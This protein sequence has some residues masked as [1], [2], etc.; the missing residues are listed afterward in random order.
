MTW[1]F[2]Q[3]KKKH[4]TVQFKAKYDERCLLLSHSLQ[5]KS[6]GEVLKCIGKKLSYLVPFLNEYNI[7]KLNNA[8]FAS[9]YCSTKAV[10][11]S[12]RTGILNFELPDSND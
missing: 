7:L 9:S 5:C 1:I 8:S 12:S 11:L 6:W 2:N 3:I 4:L 10:G